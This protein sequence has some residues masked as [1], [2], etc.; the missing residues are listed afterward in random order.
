MTALEPK[1]K[2]M[3][4]P[5][6]GFGSAR[7][8]PGQKFPWSR[9]SEVFGAARNYWIGT[10]GPDGRPHAAP[11]W[12]VWADGLFY[13]STGKESR[14]ARNLARNPAVAVHVEGAGGEVVIVEGVA[15][16][17]SDASVLAP[18]WAAYKA[19]YDW[20]VESLPFFVVHP[21]IAF[22]FKEELGDTATRWEFGGGG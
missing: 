9:A 2:R 3:R 17:V 16:E 19:K 4:S 14:K 10:A 8:P 20:P 1:A 13:F 15:E 7:R 12:G 21:R 18:I 11:V 5:G 22:S 6:Y